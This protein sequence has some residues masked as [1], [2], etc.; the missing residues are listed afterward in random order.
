MPT[1]RQLHAM[2][3]FYSRPDF[4]V[5]EIIDLPSSD[6]EDDD[7]AESTLQGHRSGSQTTVKVDQKLSVQGEGDDDFEPQNAQERRWKQEEMTRQ[8]E[9]E[10]EATRNHPHHQQ[11]QHQQH[12]KVELHSD[13]AHQWR[14]F[15]QRLAGGTV[16]R[17]QAAAAAAAGKSS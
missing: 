13:D 14:C 4:V 9:E 3:E 17:D 12:A 5:N 15:Q 16:G 10:E 8:R 2:Q 11:Q 7:E 6:D 1:P